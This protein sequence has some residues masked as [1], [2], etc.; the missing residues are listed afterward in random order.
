MPKSFDYG[1]VENN[2]YKNKFFRF[3]VPIHKG[4]VVQGKKQ[5]EDLKSQSEDILHGGDKNLKEV[6]DASM[7]NIAE[8]LMV[9]K[10]EI[11]TT[12]LANP[13]LLVNV[14]NLESAKGVKTIDEYLI[15]AK[16]YLAQLNMEVNFKKEPYDINIGDENF[17][18]LEIE[19]L[20]FG[21]SQDYYVTIRNGFALAIFAS[22]ATDTGK[23]ELFQMIEKIKMEKLD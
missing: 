21:I 22:Y 6:I 9:S 10:Y 2:V 20:T 8:L 15:Q 7:V 19:N 11:G 23:S 12:E 17:R 13:T 1:V 16:N 5:I 4:W 3:S 18:C 14:E